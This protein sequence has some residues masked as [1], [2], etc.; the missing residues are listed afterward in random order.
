[1]FSPNTARW[2]ESGWKNK[3]SACALLFLA[4]ALFSAASAS[5]QSEA[6]A[7]QQVAVVRLKSLTEEY[8][9]T[10]DVK[11][12]KSA[13][14]LTDA[15]LTQSGQALRAVG[16]DVGL[17]AG[18]I[19]QGDVWR[20]LD[21]QVRAA[22]LYAEAAAAALRGG[23]LGYEADAWGAKAVSEFYSGR[24]DQAARDAERAVARAQASG[25]MDALSRAYGMLTQVHIKRKNLAAAEASS[26]LEFSAASQA[27]DRIAVYT[28]HIDHGLLQS[29][30]LQA[31]D[32][33]G[34]VIPCLEAL[35]A[36]RA[37]YESARAIAVA[38]AYPALE[39]SLVDL[40]AV[41]AK[42]RALIENRGRK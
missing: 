14:E 28:A 29:A 9:R 26:K 32:L 6:L 12:L 4:L 16:D 1:M 13:L 23:H 17:A 34:D 7:L 41:N 15:E 30:I 25:R 21:Q 42:M 8:R 22:S 33:G 37:D 36:G 2:Q 10:L 3:T 40:L 20:M 11:P 27:S 38:L 39:K 19:K 35:E 31:C 24:D 18:L 5:P